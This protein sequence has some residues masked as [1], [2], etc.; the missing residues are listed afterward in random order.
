MTYRLI[1]SEENGVEEDCCDFNNRMSIHIK[2]PLTDEQIAAINS[3]RGQSE[4]C[5]AMG[6]ETRKIS[7]TKIE[8][9]SYC[10]LCRED[11][12]KKIINLLGKKVKQKITILVD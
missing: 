5:N 2:P 8:I 10:N 3:M 9:A 12:I 7:P 1:L 11:L 6:A 4:S